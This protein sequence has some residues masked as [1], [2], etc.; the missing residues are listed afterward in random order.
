[1]R[2]THLMVV[3]AAPVTVTVSKKLAKNKWIKR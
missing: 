2:Q 1:M 3:A